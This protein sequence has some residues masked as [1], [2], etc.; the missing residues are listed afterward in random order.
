M[1]Q[2]QWARLKGHENCGLR[3]GA[4]YRVVQLTARDAVVDVQRTQ[5][6]LP[7]A[8]FQFLSAPP[9]SWTVVARPADATG[10][11]TGWGVAYA[12]CPSC[13]NRTPLQ[14]SPP[15]LPCPRCK[16]L[17][18]VAWEEWFIGPV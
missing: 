9:H 16:G 6:S 2:V 13:R 14:G 18:R 7:R 10:L 15:R 1:A 11:P 8:A 5:V 17:F 3:R 4:W 12:V